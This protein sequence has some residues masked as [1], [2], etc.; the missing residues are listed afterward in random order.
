MELK[1][2]FEKV[3][4]SE[5]LGGGSP[6]VWSTDRAGHT[7]DG[8]SGYEENEVLCSA[9]S[10]RPDYEALPDSVV[11]IGICRATW[12]YVMAGS[13]AMMDGLAVDSLWEVHSDVECCT[14]VESD[15]TGKLHTTS[16]NRVEL[17]SDDV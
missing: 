15:G 7:A 12:E 6:K 2:T 11:E 9:K 10:F 8:V 13:A 5:S 3:A 17:D 14:T 4:K 1:P 16:S